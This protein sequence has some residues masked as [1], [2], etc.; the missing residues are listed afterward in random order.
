MLRS[1]ILQ[2][3]KNVSN[4]TN[5]HDHSN[6]NPV[7]SSLKMFKKPSIISQSNIKFCFKVLGNLLNF[8]KQDSQ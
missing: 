2:Q 1:N 4:F 3:Y 7:N 5:H 8:M 6:T